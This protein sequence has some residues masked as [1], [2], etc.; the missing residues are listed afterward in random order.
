MVSTQV[1]L[2]CSGSGDSSAVSEGRWDG[3]SGDNW[4]GRGGKFVNCQ[5]WQVFP[6]LLWLLEGYPNS[7]AAQLGEDDLDCT[8]VE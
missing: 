3:N 8:Q 7:Q 1:E 4:S 2:H 5:S 6:L